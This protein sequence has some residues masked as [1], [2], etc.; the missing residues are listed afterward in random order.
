MFK[1]PVC[2]NTKF[3]G[4]QVLRAEVIVD[5]N[6]NFESNLECGLDAAIYDSS[7]PYGPYTCTK[8]GKE[9]DELN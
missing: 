7:E 4:H 6:N 2:G 1:C 8:C 3:V 9:V 5:G